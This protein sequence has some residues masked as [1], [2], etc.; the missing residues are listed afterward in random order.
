M[1]GV[2]A[3][4]ATLVATLRRILPSSRSRFRD[5]GLAGVVGD[6]PA[7]ARLGHGHLVVAQAVAADLAGHEVIAGD[8]DLLVLGV[9]VEAH[10][11][12][13]V[14]QRTGDGLD[15]VGRRDE[16]HVGQVEVDFE[17]VVAEG[18]VL[19]GVEHLE[20]RGARVASPVGA[21]LVDLVEQEDRVHGPGLGDGADDAARLRADVRA[22]VATDLCFVADAAERDPHELAPEG[23]CHRRAE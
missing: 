20:Q 12:H 11:L 8:G 13:A 1:T 4:A 2:S 22:P 23:A 3:P 10:D 14:E 6:D 17:V 9:A 7:N 21:D 18:V 16:Q 5:A 15:H 19:R